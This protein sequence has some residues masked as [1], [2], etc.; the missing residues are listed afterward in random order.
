MRPLA[1][2]WTSLWNPRKKSLCACTNNLKIL[3][4]FGGRSKRN[5]SQNPLH[6]F[7]LVSSLPLAGRKQSHE[8][9]QSKIHASV[10]MRAPLQMVHAITSPMVPF[11]VLNPLNHLT[12][13]HQCVEDHQHPRSWHCHRSPFQKNANPSRR[14]C[15]P[16]HRVIKAIVTN[17]PREHALRK[18][19]ARTPKAIMCGIGGHLHQMQLECVFLLLMVSRH[20]TCLP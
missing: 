15:K 2:S 19:S 4:Y 13:S 5:A 11:Q 3:R 1:K 6:L 9:R 7:F 10:K 18:K 8:C 12:E 16:S 20:A 17:R 14:L